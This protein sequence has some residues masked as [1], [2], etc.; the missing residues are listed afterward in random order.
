M[1]IRA[2]VTPSFVQLIPAIS[3]LTPLTTIIP[4]VAVLAVS[5]LKDAVDDFVSHVLYE[6]QG[7]AATCH[8]I[9]K[10]KKLFWEGVGF[11]NVFNVILLTYSIAGLFH[12]HICACLVEIHYKFPISL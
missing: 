12:Y 2:L 3:S 7:M 9:A 5:A 8:V 6:H 1:F 11:V 4:L 10:E